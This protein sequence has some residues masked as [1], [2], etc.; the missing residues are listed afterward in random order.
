MLW[1]TPAQ[2][3]EAVHVP[4]CRLTSHPRSCPNR[5]P[6]LL[7]ASLL[8]ATCTPPCPRA[9]AGS[10]RIIL[11]PGSHIIL[12]YSSLPLSEH[13][14]STLSLL[15]Y[16]LWRRLVRGRRLRRNSTEDKSYSTAKPDLR[17]YRYKYSSQYIFYLFNVLLYM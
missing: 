15:Y 4:S 5:R 3:G 11:L 14:T 9:L 10:Y 1:F 7:Q 6:A 2:V 8:L 17:L 16:C 13:S 12:P